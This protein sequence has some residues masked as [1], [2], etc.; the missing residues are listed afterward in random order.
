[1]ILAEDLLI[2]RQ[3]ALKEWF[4]LRIL[5][6]Y[7]VQTREVVQAPRHIVMIC[8]EGLLA[9]RQSTLEE[10]LDLRILA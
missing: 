4:G 7:Q 2:D 10:R 6:L 8:P 1:M 9:D 3:R 5:A